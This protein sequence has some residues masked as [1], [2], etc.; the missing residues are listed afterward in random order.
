MDAS[1][2]VHSF[3]NFNERRKLRTRWLI[4]CALVAV[5]LFYFI[6]DPLESRFMPQC[7]FYKITGLKCI[8]CG[9]QRMAHALLHGD[10]VGAFRANALALVSLPFIMFLVWVETQRKKRP[11]LYIKVFST[12]L[13]ITVGVVMSVWFIARNLLCI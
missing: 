5:A 8:G 7:V 10:L 11:G 4:L 13:I 12:T 9:S 6:F 3:F 2:H 1:D